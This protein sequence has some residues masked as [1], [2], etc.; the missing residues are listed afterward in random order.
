[1]VG[2]RSIEREKPIPNLGVGLA[3]QGVPSGHP[4]EVAADRCG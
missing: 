1:M 4:R 2:V 3:A